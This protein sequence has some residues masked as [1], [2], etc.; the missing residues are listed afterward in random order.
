VKRRYADDATFEQQ[1]NENHSGNIQ[2]KLNPGSYTFEY[3]G[4]NADGMYNPEIQKL[5]IH[6]ATPFWK[7]IWFFALISATVI[8]IV[9]YYFWQ[10]DQSRIKLEKLRYQIARDLHDDMGSN[11]SNIK[12]ISELE[13]LKNPQA[14]DTSYSK[15]AEKSRI[16]ME[17][18]SDIVWSINPNNDDLSKVITKIQV[19]A[20][21][22]LESKNIE[23]KMD[24]P[25]IPDKI[26]INLD[27]RRHFHM[28]CK[29]AFNNIAKYSKADMATFS[30]LL[31]N[32][33]IYT[34]ISNN[35]V[36]FHSMVKKKIP[37]KNQRQKRTR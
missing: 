13:I 23:L 27:Q 8:G 28:I 20:I 17:N 34:V 11:L 3:T 15:I 4:S 10:K 12:M 25:S 18:M 22:I 2:Y 33:R 19:F 29:E 26:E 24:I 31:K 5:Y 35:G 1:F 16:V 36:G 21:E 9:Y 14:N 37:N 6:I 7:S 30:I 32:Q